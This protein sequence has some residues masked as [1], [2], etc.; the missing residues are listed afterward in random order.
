M[1]P[2]KKAAGKAKAASK[3][4][5][6]KATG[7]TKEA[8][9]NKKPAGKR[10]GSPDSSSGSESEQ[11]MMK[12]RGKPAQKRAKTGIESKEIAPESEVPAARGPH[13][14]FDL[15]AM[16]LSFL[17]EV[18]LPPGQSTSKPQFS[19]LYDK[20]LEYQAKS[21]STA[22]CVIPDAPVDSSKAKNKAN[23][24][25]TTE[26]QKSGRLESAVF[27]DPMEGAPWDIALVDLKVCDPV[28][29][30]PKERK[31]FA[32]APQVNCR[33]PYGA[34]DEPLRRAECGWSVPHAAC[35][36]GGA[37]S[38]LYKR[39]RHGGGEAIGFPF[40]EVRARKDAAGREVG[41]SE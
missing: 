29:F 40:W 39:K 9:E 20:V 22:Q 37:W 25:D 33:G 11:Y 41:L 13:D 17:A 26:E 7:N 23:T 4:A 38:G 36:G 31:Q 6:K 3:S 14:K 24:K 2:R 30:P 35:M 10:A 34:G 16:E 19:A 8:T 21:D 27:E 18:Y 28:V 5:P 12:S 32:T 15:Y 1:P